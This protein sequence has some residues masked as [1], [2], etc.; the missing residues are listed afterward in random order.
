MKVKSIF[1]YLTV[2]IIATGSLFVGSVSIDVTKILKAETLENRIFF[3]L[4]LPH[5][6]FTFFAGFILALGGGL[7]QTIFR[8]ELTTPYTLGI[9]SGAMFG[10]G[11]AIKLGLV[12]LFFGVSSIYIFGFLGAFSSVILLLYLS[13]FLQRD[14]TSSLLLLGIALSLFYSSALLILFYMGDPIQNDS[15]LRYSMGSLSVVGWI[16]PTVIAITATLF[17]VVA[18]LYRFELGLLALS[19]QMAKQKGVNVKRVERVLLLT[20]SLAIGVLISISGP[21]GFVG[22]V[23]PHMVAKIYAV[24]LHKRV[25]YNGIFGGIFLILCDMIARTLQTQGELPIGII[26]TLI[27]VPFFIYLILKRR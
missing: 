21:I 17:G 18:Y 6:V 9:S 24:S 8:N 11:I 5:L 20:T 14:T 10:A 16:E 22:L 19:S 7:F 25:I 27:G 3:E 23:V 26:T 15:L 13:R 12:G 4:R 1:I 2:L